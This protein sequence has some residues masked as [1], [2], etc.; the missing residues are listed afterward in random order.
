MEKNAAELQN[1]DGLGKQTADD[2]NVAFH[3]TGC[4]TK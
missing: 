3:S 4:V 2:N 1:C